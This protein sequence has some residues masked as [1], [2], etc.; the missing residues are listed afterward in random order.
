M[1]ETL[2]LP[3]PD[4]C[5]GPGTTLHVARA[6]RGPLALL[7]HGYPLDHRMWLDTLHGPLAAQRTLLAPDLRGHGSSP[8]AGAGVH[9]MEQ[10]A[11]DAAALL[12]SCAEGPV[13]VVGLSMGGYVAFALWAMAPELVRSLV[14]VDTKAAA[15]DAAAR[16][17][18]DAAVAAVLDSGRPAL[19]TG[20]AAKLLAPRPTGDAAGQLLRARLA[21]MIEAQ[22]VETIVADLR[23]LRD[24]PD[25]TA[26]LGSITVPTLVVVGEHDAITPVAGAKAMAAAIPGARCAVVPGA[27]HLVPMEQPEVFA[28]GVGAFLASQ[29]STD[30]G[31]LQP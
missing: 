4:T 17:G 3:V 20:M 19:A 31:A 12:R 11:A 7:L 8:W 5:H 25:R 26:M 30:P 1:I 18:R 28:Q 9:S 29:Q 16:A 15:D 13:D 23:G 27:G 2:H 6:G 14:L 24:R 21:S 22:S 10:F